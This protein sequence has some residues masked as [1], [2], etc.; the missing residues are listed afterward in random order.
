V[1]AFLDFIART[2]R[3]RSVGYPTGAGLNARTQP[4]RAIAADWL[5]AADEWETLSD[6]GAMIAL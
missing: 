4:P 6:A 1:H 3:L 2:K 5:A